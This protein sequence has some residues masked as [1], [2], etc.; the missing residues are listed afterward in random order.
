MWYA[1]ANIHSR[2]PLQLSRSYRTAGILTAVP[3]RSCDHSVDG[4]RPH[5]TTGPTSGQRKAACPCANVNP[6][7]THGA[8]T[9]TSDFCQECSFETHGNSNTTP[10]PNPPY[11]ARL[12]DVGSDAHTPRRFVFSRLLSY[13]TWR[14][15][16][17][18]CLSDRVDAWLDG[19]CHCEDPGVW[20]L[21]PVS[22]RVH[23]LCS[24][25]SR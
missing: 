5:A 3:Q 16:Q 9:D 11:S 8:R 14:V 13:F 23:A 18:Q 17:W 7:K 22:P 12:R 24:A 4:I 25:P 2:A 20:V 19:M 1:D 21:R 15:S 10:G 6:W